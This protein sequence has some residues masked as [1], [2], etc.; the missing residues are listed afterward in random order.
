M[1]KRLAYLVVVI[2]VVSSSYYL[3]YSSRDAEVEGLKKLQA[4]TTIELSK[5]SQ[6]LDDLLK[7]LKDGQNL[8][9]LLNSDLAFLFDLYTKSLS[10]KD[11]S[12]QKESSI[13][14]K[15]DEIPP[16][17]LEML[18]KNSLNFNPK[19]IPSKMSI[20]SFAKELLDLSM[21]GIVKPDEYKPPKSDKKIAFNT[22][23]DTNGSSNA[24]ERN[25]TTKLYANFDTNG[26][27]DDRVVAKWYRKDTRELVLFDFYP[28]IQNSDKNNVWINKNNGWDKGQYTVEI[29][30]PTSGLE[31][32][33]EGE[34]EVK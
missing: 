27:D 33:T 22:K 8:N 24:F 18:L 17:E 10:S 13:F 21:R 34:F 20:N 32:I 3:G 31:K 26:F 7:R 30:S 6:K 2:A 25:A 9:S 23:N 4:K 1:K 16:S 12:S 11:N 19:D 5:E 28:V 15:I 29:Y 14:S